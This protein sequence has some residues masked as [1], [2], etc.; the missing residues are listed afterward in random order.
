MP[1]CTD[2][3]CLMESREPAG[4]QESDQA[5]KATLPWASHQCQSQ[6]SWNGDL[7]SDA[8]QIRGDSQTSG[9]LSQQLWMSAFERTCEMVDLSPLWDPRGEFTSS[10]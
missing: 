8:P 10:I 2:S 1:M 9:D 7:F 5:Q 6:E 4:E 3:Q